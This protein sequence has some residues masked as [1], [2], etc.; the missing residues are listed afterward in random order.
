ME[1]VHAFDVMT[2]VLAWLL[3]GTPPRGGDTGMASP[4]VSA[5]PVQAAFSATG[6]E[7]RIR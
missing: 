3:V 2:G 6:A 5:S 7:L 1:R 4:R